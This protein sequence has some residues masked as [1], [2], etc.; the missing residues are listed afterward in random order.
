MMHN[1][2]LINEPLNR[3]GDFEL[4][5]WRRLDRAHRFI[6]RLVKQIHTH[7]RK[8]TRRI[9]WLFNEPHNV[10]VFVNFGNTKLFWILDMTQQNLSGWSLWPTCSPRILEV[11]YKLRKTLLEHVVT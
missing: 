6:D 9:F 7:K 1:L 3:V 4:A 5:A 8:I 10:S 2:F 11:V